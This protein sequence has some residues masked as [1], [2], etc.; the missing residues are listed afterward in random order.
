[1][2]KALSEIKKPVTAQELYRK[3]QKSEI[4]LVTLYRT[5]D[6][7]ERKEILRRVDLRKDAIYYELN[8]EH[9]HHIV[10][11]NCDKLEDFKSREIEKVLEKIIKNSSKFKN[12]NEHS[13]ELFGV[14][15]ACT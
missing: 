4:D 7:F 11:T 9:H 12:I 15:K 10:C 2:L 1:V 8:T 3:L 14:C 13:L 6:S 5:L